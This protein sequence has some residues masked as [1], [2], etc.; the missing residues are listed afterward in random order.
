MRMWPWPEKRSEPVA[1]L[2]VGT[3]KVS[4]VVG[5]CR[6]D[7]GIVITGFGR[8]ESRGVRKSEVVDRDNAETCVHGAVLAA[9]QMSE[10]E[11]NSVMIA[12]SGGQLQSVVNRSSVPIRHAGVG[13][14]FE[15]TREVSRMAKAITLPPEREIIHTIPQLFYIDDCDPVEKPLGL[16]GQ[17]L[18]L[19]MLILHV[20]QNRVHNAV[21]MVRDLNI[22]VADVVFGGLYAAMVSVTRA[23]KENGAIVIDLG[24]GTTSYVAYTNN[25]VASVGS[26]AVGGDHVTNDIALAFRITN[27]QA[28]TL[29]KESGSARIDPAL[30]HQRVAVEADEGRRTQTVNHGT[31][32]TVINARITELF[33]I[34]R[35]KLAAE[36]VLPH[37]AAGVVL[38]GGGAR[39]RDV[40]KVA[41]HVFGL[42]CSIGH[43]LEVSGQAEVTDVPDYAASIGVV[44]HALRFSQAN[45]TS[46]GE[47]LR[48]LLGIG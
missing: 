29:K 32:T 5:E 22:D 3:S 42:P 23:Q 9:E 46:P 43:P 4:V 6:E 19:D 44:R 18:A 12:F 24:G 26:L 13:I 48:R 25:I 20:L 45:K 40:E 36:R 21:N 11:I 34:I 16:F 2:E 47:R 33:G 41:E 17:R 15:D 37:I 39:L 10:V 27:K 8:H 7:G 31:L 1:V 35:D 30:H 28:E 14:S 38:T